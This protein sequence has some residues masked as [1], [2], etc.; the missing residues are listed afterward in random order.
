MLPEMGKYQSCMPCECRLL[1]EQRV[2]YV[3]V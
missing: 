2:Q 3:L 1:F